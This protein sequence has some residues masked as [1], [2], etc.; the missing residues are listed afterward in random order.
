[1]SFPYVNVQM[2]DRSVFGLDESAA[3][4]RLFAATGYNNLMSVPAVV[5]ISGMEFSVGVR[6]QAGSGKIVAGVPSG[7]TTVLVNFSDGGPS[8]DN[9][10]AQT[11]FSND[12]WSNSTLYAANIPRDGTGATFATDL[13]ADDWL[14][15]RVVANLSTSAGIGVLDVHV[16]YVFGKPGGVA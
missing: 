11:Y 1:M 4:Y 3:T 5:D 13:D 15:F 16:A 9:A 12:T 6:G 8:G 2:L 10:T 7:T 14:N